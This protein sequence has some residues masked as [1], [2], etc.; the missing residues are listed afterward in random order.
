MDGLS[1]EAQAV[2]DQYFSIGTIPQISPVKWNVF[3]P[4]KDGTLA[5]ELTKGRRELYIVGGAVAVAAIGIWIYK[6]G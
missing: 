6:N 1:P 3:T 2:R 5:A 4:F